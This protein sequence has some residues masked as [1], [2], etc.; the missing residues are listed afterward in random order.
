MQSFNDTCSFLWPDGIKYDRV[1]LVLTDQASYML[2]A[3]SALKMLYNKLSH[4]TC[5]VHALHRVCESVHMKYCKANDFVSLMKKVLLKSP[6]RVQLYKEITNLPLPPEP[7]VTR[8]G[9]WIKNAVFYAENFNRITEFLQE[10]DSSQSEAVANI[11]ILSVN[12]DV[13]IELLA[14]YKFN[15]LVQSITMLNTQGLS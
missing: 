11:K 8:W 13:K 12:K 2:S 7:V 1:W 9:T 14:V 4:V 15:F 5:I 6:Y 3:L 10:L